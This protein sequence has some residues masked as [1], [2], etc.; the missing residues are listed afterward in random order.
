MFC[1]K[2]GAN[3]AASSQYCP[4][5]GTL[6]PDAVQAGINS[7]MASD[8]GSKLARRLPVLAILWIVFGVLEAARAAAVHVFTRVAQFWFT[9]PDWGQWAGPWV[10]AWI[11]A[12]SVFTAVLAFITAWGLYERLPWGR[13]VALVASIFALTH[14]PFG[15]ILGVYTLIVL[16]AGDAGV[17]YDRIARV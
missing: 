10:L 8:A 15:T 16:L 11:V 5:C 7:A 14:P 6:L 9:G 13:I 1:D 2:C 17:Q 3:V 12:W 4:R